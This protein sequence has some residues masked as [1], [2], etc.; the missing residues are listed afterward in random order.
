MAHAHH[1]RHDAPTPAEELADLPVEPEMPQGDVPPE[2]SEE[3]ATGV[4][5]LPAAPR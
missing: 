5:D 2:P 4:P 1:P 3:S